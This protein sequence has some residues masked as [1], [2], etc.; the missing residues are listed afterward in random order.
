MTLCDQTVNDVIVIVIIMER[1]NYK[2]IKIY[3]FG[4]AIV[5]VG[6]YLARSISQIRFR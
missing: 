4:D 5:I 6:I 3:T 2:S 1:F